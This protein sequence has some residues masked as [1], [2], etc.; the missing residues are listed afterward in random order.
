MDPTKCFFLGIELRITSCTMDQWTVTLSKV[1]TM[2]Y[3]NKLVTTE[4]SDHY[5]EMSCLERIFPMDWCT[6]SFRSSNM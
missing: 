6:K 3:I 1:F 2:D 5:I 4:T